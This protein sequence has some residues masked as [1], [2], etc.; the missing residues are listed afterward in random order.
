MASPPTSILKK[1]PGRPKTTGLSDAM[2]SMNI[3]DN[4]QPVKGLLPYPCITGHWEA[5]NHSIGVMKSHCMMRILF[6]ARLTADDFCITWIDT[7]TLRIKVKWP[8]FMQFSL[9]MACLD[10]FSDGSNPPNIHYNYPEDHKVYYSMGAVTAA[11]KDTE[12]H[13]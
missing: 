13:I 12:G 7:Q 11:L 1:K 2:A 5:F 9:L 3:A 4:P 8:L 10:Q 6:H